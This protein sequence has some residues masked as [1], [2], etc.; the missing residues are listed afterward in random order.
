M[1]SPASAE[2]QAQ[3]CAGCGAAGH[4]PVIVWD[5]SQE[6][7]GVVLVPVFGFYDEND[8]VA[9]LCADC[10]AKLRRRRR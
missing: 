9:L 2:T 10:R 4:P 1:S 8:R 5:R 3:H 7:E 6:P